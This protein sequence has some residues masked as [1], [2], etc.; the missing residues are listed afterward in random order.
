VSR[1][2]LGGGGISVR[3]ELGFWLVSLVGVLALLAPVAASAG[4]SSA[5]KLRPVCVE[6]NFPG[7]LH[8][9]IGYC[10]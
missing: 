5:A 10:P 2:S 6:R 8:I 4:S 7:G 3:H 9:Q 1:V